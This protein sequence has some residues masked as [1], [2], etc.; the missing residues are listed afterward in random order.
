MATSK[1]KKKT[2]NASRSRS[3]ARPTPAP[4]TGR[5]H[6]RRSSRWL[7]AS[8]GFVALVLLV[9]VLLTRS[10]GGRDDGDATGDRPADIAATGNLLRTEA[11]WPPQPAGLRQRVEAAG[12]PPVGDESFHVHALLSVYVDGEKVPVPANIG[13]DP[14]SGYHSPLHTHTPDGV[15]HFEADDPAPFTLQQVFAMWGVEFTRDR[16]GAYTSNGDE[17]I[18]VYVNGGVVAGPGHEIRE[19][20]NIVVA[21]GKA[22][23]FPTEPPADALQDT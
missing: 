1:N 12:F 9:G 17:R 5:T 18:H 2:T 3:S 20:D 13:I 21:Y 6:G 10:G 15:I 11:P 23:S 8:V 4:P 14:S 22:G 19:G 16:L 7:L